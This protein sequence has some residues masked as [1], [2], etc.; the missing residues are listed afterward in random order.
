MNKTNPI[1]HDKLQS[2]RDH[3]CL[4]V[5]R[6]HRST[7]LNASTSL[8]ILRIA[9]LGFYFHVIQSGNKKGQLIISVTV[10]YVSLKYN[11]LQ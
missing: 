11:Q 1:I 4:M 2:F 7:S 6:D 10:Y 9:A 5:L 8:K 3:L